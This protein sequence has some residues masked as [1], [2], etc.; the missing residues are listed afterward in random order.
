M[1]NSTSDI[2]PDPSEL[3]IKDK[4]ILFEKN[5]VKLNNLES[6]ETSK[7]F[8]KSRVTN[9][10]KFEPQTSTSDSNNN[11]Q[12]T[13]SP[14]EV[15]P[16]SIASSRHS[17]TFEARKPKPNI[18]SSS[19]SANKSSVKKIQFMTEVFNDLDCF[20]DKELNEIDIKKNKNTIKDRQYTQT[21]TKN[22]DEFND[23]LETLTRI[24]DE[25][26][27]DAEAKNQT[28][29]VDL[30][31][32]METQQESIKRW[33]ISRLEMEIIKQES[34][35][36]KINQVLQKIIQID[37]ENITL[38]IN[39]ERHYLVAMNRLQCCLT[40]IKRLSD[41][42]IEIR[43][44]PFNRNGRMVISRIM[45]EVKQ[46][47]FDRHDRTEN[48]YVVCVLKYGNHICATKPIQITDDIR[49]VKFPERFILDRVFLDFEM[50][51]EVYGTTFMRKRSSIR[52]TML[53]KYGFVNVTFEDGGKKRW[54]M[55][56]V[57]PSDLNPL[58]CKILMK[59]RNKFTVNVNFS[60]ILH[61]LYMK[62][63][64]K[65]TTHLSG[66]LLKICF[67]IKDEYLLLDLHNFDSDAVIPVVPEVSLVPYTFLLKFNHYVER[68][69]F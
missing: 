53:K 58:R 2:D 12:S 30:D 46:R 21:I 51:L 60:A 45:L 28:F 67:D 3:S 42:T 69:E 54:N 16:S 18:Q 41:S 55:I 11:Q 56:E 35:L 59:I 50:R 26:R 63:W 29:K 37:H 32:S 6:K 39:I 38:V 34:L 22:D 25:Y 23:V 10:K 13:P 43:K 24:R 49:V 27:S 14:Q 9:L 62:K 5:A 61:V 40:E 64:R 57:I 66:H 4:L 47:Y 36:A 19:K 1:V 17:L 20:I 68:N 65:T 33:Q 7:V 44:A 48:E 31:E 52:D 8:P 15:T